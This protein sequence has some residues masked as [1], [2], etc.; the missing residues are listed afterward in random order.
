MM[1][2]LPLGVVRTTGRPVVMVAVADV[3]SKVGVGMNVING[4]EVENLV[5]LELGYLVVSDGDEDGDLVV[6]D[7]EENEALVVVDEEV[8]GR[9]D[10]LVGLYAEADGATLGLVGMDDSD[11]PFV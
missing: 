6:R 1:L 2:R 9:V 10:G 8:L 3:P 11:E 5:G 4:D 7:G